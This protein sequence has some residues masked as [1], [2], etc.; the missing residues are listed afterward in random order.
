[1]ER[2]F[3]VRSPSLAIPAPTIISPTATLFLDRN[4]VAIA[5]AAHQ[6]DGGPRP[7]PRASNKE[8]GHAVGSANRSERCGIVI[9]TGSTRR[10]PV[11]SISMPAGICIAAIPLN[12]SLSSAERRRQEPSSL[13]ISARSLHDRAKDT[14][15][16]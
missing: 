9:I 6:A 12:Y 2:D 8:A 10:R 13:V 16:V 14:T 11:R 4:H 1:M 15:E 7:D 3:E 5:L